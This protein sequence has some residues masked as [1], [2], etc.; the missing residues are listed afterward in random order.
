MKFLPKL[1][2]ASFKYTKVN[3]DSA[4]KLEESTQHHTATVISVKGAFCQLYLVF[5]INKTQQA[6]SGTS[7]STQKLLEPHFMNLIG[8]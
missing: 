8:L 5:F 6:P 7:A 4:A 1:E 3:F 2:P